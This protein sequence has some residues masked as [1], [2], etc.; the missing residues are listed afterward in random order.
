MIFNNNC[1][2]NWYIFA[3]KFGHIYVKIRKKHRNI[4]L[5]HSSNWVFI[6]KTCNSLPVYDAQMF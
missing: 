1:L 5:L 3:L 2:S 4:G 6:L